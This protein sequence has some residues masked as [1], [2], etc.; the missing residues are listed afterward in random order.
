[1]RVPDPRKRAP[2]DVV[3]AIIG[4]EAGAGIGLLAFG[5]TP[6]A[7]LGLAVA[8]ALVGAGAIRARNAMVRRWLRA[9]LRAAR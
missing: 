4:A 5:A 6:L 9:Q 2:R 1:M 3:A 7:P 8:G